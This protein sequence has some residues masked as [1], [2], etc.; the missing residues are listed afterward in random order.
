MLVQ[1]EDKQEKKKKG[2]K[3]DG[4]GKHSAK[5]R[6]HSQSSPELLDLVGNICHLQH[7]NVKTERAATWKGSDLKN[8][9]ALA[10]IM[11]IRPSQ[12]VAMLIKYLAGVG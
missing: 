11:I 4:A 6:M 12:Q 8:G 2:G 3:C 9:P 5:S 1:A 10:G 7:G